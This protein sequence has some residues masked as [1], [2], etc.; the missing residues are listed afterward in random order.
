MDQT[1]SK[2]WP[3][4]PGWFWFYGSLFHNSPKKI[5]PVEVV[6]DRSAK[7]VYIATGTFL[8]KS[9]TSGT[10]FWLPLRVP[11]PPRIIEELVALDLERGDRAAG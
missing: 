7:L 1:W 6:R 5:V 9:E 4:E 2:V 10:S 3:T 11:D 8:Y